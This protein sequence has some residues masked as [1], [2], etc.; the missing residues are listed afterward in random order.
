MGGSP[1]LVVMGDNSSL[2]G[3]GFESRQ[4]VLDGHDIFNI[5]LLLK[6]YCLFEKTEYKIKRG[7]DWPIFKW[8]TTFWGVV[9][10]KVCRVVTSD[11]RGQFHKTL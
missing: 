7:R 1:G 3:N 5:D 2:R 10:G 6:L 9:C 4:H 8:K 11:T